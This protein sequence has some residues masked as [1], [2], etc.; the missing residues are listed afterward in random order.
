MDDE[1]FSAAN[2]VMDV[3]RLADLDTIEATFA[4]L[5]KAARRYPNSDQRRAE[6]NAALEILRDVDKRAQQVMESFWAPLDGSA[7]A[8][9]ATR[10]AAQL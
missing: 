5:Y 7:V 6:L 3:P 10:L 1:G 9:S 4:R 2:Q 8:P